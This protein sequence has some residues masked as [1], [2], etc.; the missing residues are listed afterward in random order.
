MTDDHKDEVT[1]HGLVCPRPL[2]HEDTI[3]L[4]H[5]SGGRMTQRLIET[6]FY[7]PFENACM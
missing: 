1:I 3:V 4:G 5:G 2:S 7:P 6:T